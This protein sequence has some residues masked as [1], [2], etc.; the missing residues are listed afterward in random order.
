MDRAQDATLTNRGTR[1]SKRATRKG[2][3]LHL[4]NTQVPSAFRAVGGEQRASGASS[5]PSGE[6]SPSQGRIR[7]KKEPQKKNNWI[8]R[9]DRAS[10]V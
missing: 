1:R 2:D 8:Q 6:R 9:P 10:G 7:S 4:H 3:G 5:L